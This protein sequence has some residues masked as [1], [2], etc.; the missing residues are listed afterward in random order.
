MFTECETFFYYKMFIEIIWNNDFK[1]KFRLIVCLYYYCNIY[2]KKLLKYIIYSIYYKTVKIS[3]PYE[4][5]MRVT[6]HFISNIIFF[7]LYY[8]RVKIIDRK[9]QFG[10]NLIGIFSNKYIQ[11]K[12]LTVLKM[13][14]NWWKSM[15]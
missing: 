3:L 1:K 9:L 6:L 13:E 11:N 15:L 2:A 7:S 5:H 12:L 10:N 8:L 4:A 14:G